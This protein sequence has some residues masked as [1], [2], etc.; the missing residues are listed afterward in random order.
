[1]VPVRVVM[2]ERVT[3]HPMPETREDPGDRNDIDAGLMLM[4]QHRSFIVVVGRCQFSF[5]SANR[6]GISTVTRLGN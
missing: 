3:V 6:H 1:M 2:R 5:R 4:Q